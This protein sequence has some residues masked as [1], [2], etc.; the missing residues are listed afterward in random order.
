MSRPIAAGLLFV[1]TT[2][3]LA[4]TITFNEVR[5][6]RVVANGAGS[7]VSGGYTLTPR[8]GNANGFIVAGSYQPRDNPQGNQALVNNGT[9]NLMC[10]NWVD[11][12][13]ASVGGAPFDL[14]SVEIGGTF[15]QEQVHRWS[16][17]GVV[18]IVGHRA[19]GGHNLVFQLELGSD[20]ELHAVNLGWTG[21]SSVEFLPEHSLIG[22]GPNDYEFTLDNLAVSDPP[23]PADFNA[24]GQVDFFDYL[25]FSGA[26][27]VEDSAADFNG[28]ATVDFFDYLD[29]VGAFDAGCD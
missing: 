28:D 17:A 7:F 14:A 19:D 12:E 13:L 11:L 4:G 18:N 22:T 20:F 5:P 9:P 24:D 10:G 25:D 21:L 26:L 16:W 29:F 8:A 6:V 1:P 27:D 15:D 2:C 23:C 3:C